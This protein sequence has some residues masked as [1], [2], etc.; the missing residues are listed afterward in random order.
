MICQGQRVVLRDE[1][2]DDK[3]VTRMFTDTSAPARWENCR[4]EMEQYADE[5]L[6]LHQVEGEMDVGCLTQI[7][8]P[9]NMVSRS[10]NF[11]SF[12]FLTLI[13]HISPSISFSFLT[14]VCG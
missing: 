4:D 6:S 3:G 10:N 5:L 11:R 12:L 8:I 2:E 9:Q 1:E 7:S 13:P 14:L